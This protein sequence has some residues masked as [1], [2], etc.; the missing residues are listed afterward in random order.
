MRTLDC[1]RCWFSR[2][3]RVAA[4]PATD[5]QYDCAHPDRARAVQRPTAMLGPTGLVQLA[6]CPRNK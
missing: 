1:S 5:I 4:G 6:F 2:R 3:K